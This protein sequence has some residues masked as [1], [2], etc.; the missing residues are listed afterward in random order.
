VDSKSY[1]ECDL[2]DDSVQEANMRILLPS[3]GLTH[4]N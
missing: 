2:H 3:L 4:G 1:M